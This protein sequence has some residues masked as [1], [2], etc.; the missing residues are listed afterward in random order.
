MVYLKLIFHGYISKNHDVFQLQCKPTCSIFLL[1]PKGRNFSSLDGWQHQNLL[2]LKDFS[3]TKLINNRTKNLTWSLSLR[4][5]HLHQT[6]ITAQPQWRVNYIQVI[7]P[8]ILFN[9]YVTWEIILEKYPRT[10]NSLLS[11]QFNDYI[12]CICNCAFSTSNKNTIQEH[13]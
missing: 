1:A 9:R 13:C 11:S 5:L 3:K 6:T 7:F 2:W 12:L 10:S 4:F 8:R